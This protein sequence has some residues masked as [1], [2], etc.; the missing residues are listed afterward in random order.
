MPPPRDSSAETPEQIVQALTD[1][2]AGHP[3][4]TLLEDGK[5][6]FDFRSARHSLTASHG[7]ALLRV[8]SDD[9]NLVRSVVSITPKNG[10]LRLACLR[11]GQTQPKTLQLTAARERRVPSARDRGRDRFLRLLE[12]VV[13]REFHEWS[14]EGF[15]ASMDLER[16]FGPAYVRGSQHRGRDAWAVIAVSAHESS[17]IVDGILTAGVLWLHACRERAAGRT[18]FRGLRLILPQGSAALTAARLAWMN[19]AAAEWELFELDD[20]GEQ[21]SPR[22]FANSGNLSMTLLHRPDEAA[23]LERFAASI[24]AVQ[25]LVPAHEWPRTETLVRSTSEIAFLLHGFEFARTRLQVAPNSFAHLFVTTVGNG[26]DETPLTPATHESLRARVAELFA[27]RRSLS[28][29]P[30]FPR[31]TEQPRRRIGTQQQ[32]AAHARLRASPVLLPRSARSTAQAQDPLF[33]AAPERWLESVLRA[34]LSSLTRGLAAEPASA[35][36]LLH[37]RRALAQAGQRHAASSL[38]QTH[39]GEDDDD[40]RGNRADAPFPRDSNSPGRQVIPRFDPRFLYSQV[41]AQAGASDRRR[42][43]LLGL[44][45]DGRIAVIEI[46]AEEDLHFALQGLDYWIRVRA[47]H[48][49][50]PDPGHPL[51]TFQRHGYFTTAILSPLP[52]RLFLVAPALRIHPATEVVLQYLSPEVDWTL[53]ALDERWRE[54]LRV[55]WRRSSR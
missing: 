10:N 4:A 54:K 27:R 9:R 30:N 33:R 38:L 1:F 43:D 51:G 39:D 3:E 5:Q 44:T 48:L 7:R 14:T 24:A 18:L 25:A 28:F 37:R 46:K 6:L 34:E 41:T 19:P 22:L 53:I 12:N 21:L 20:A 52:P 42:I 29:A 35:P 11:P 45:L 16:S 26:A 8:W 49:A 50:P 32:D 2:L 23:A 55:V 13:S 47:Q 15:R 40:N 36:P 31:R 17:S